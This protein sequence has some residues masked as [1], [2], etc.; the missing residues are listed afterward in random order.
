MLAAAHV[1]FIFITEGNVRDYIARA[2]RGEVGIDETWDA[3]VAEWLD[4]G[5]Q[6]MTY[7]ANAWYTCVSK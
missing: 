1:F 2:I 5:G 6:E 4:Q 7:E 3:M